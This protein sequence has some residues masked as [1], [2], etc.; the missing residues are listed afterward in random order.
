MCITINT[1]ESCMD[2]PACMTTEEIKMATLD[3]EHL[4]LLLKLICHSWPLMKIEVQNKLQ[5]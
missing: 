5:T 1:I 3:D 4:V 2:I